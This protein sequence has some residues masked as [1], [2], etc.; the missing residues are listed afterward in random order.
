MQDNLHGITGLHS[1]DEPQ[2][3]QRDAGLYHWI[4]IQFR[5]EHRLLCQHWLHQVVYWLAHVHCYHS[6]FC[7]H[8]CNW[9][10]LYAPY[11]KVCMY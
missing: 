10:E 5:C 7:C 1:R 8:L 6:C 4:C 11:T 3:V 9:D 2:G